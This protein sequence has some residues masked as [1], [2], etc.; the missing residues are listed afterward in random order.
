MTPDIPTILLLLIIMQI[1]MVIALSCQFFSKSYQGV[2]WWLTSVCLIATGYALTLLREIP[3]LAPPIIFF[4]NMLFILSAASMYIG[5]SRFVNKKENWL[6]LASVVI[7]YI[8][9]FAY[10]LFIQDDIN[11]RTIT[12]STCFSFIM[13]L[14]AHLFYRHKDPATRVTAI[15]LAYAL[16]IYSGFFAFRACF[17]IIA[18]HNKYLLFHGYGLAVRNP[19]DCIWHQQPLHPLF[20]CHDQPTRNSRGLG[21]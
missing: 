16:F 2:G 17:S 18:P 10:F 7:A 4:S 6:L 3:G 1:C 15:V 11:R 9:V 21:G 13:F 5:C 19:F 8:C 20:Y 14:S 12:L